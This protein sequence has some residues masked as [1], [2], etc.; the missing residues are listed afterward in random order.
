MKT[1]Y[2]ADFKNMNETN[3]KDTQITLTKAASAI[4]MVD[5]EHVLV[6]WDILRNYKLENSKKQ[7]YLSLRE[8]YKEINAKRQSSTWWIPE[9]LRKES[10][11]DLTLRS[12]RSQTF[13][14]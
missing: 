2:V 7:L 1:D 13:P 6:C 9:T 14:K 5:F 12:S 4:F 3:Y 11:K 10:R 8:I